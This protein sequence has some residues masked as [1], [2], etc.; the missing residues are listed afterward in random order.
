M[1]D[2]GALRVVLVC[3]FAAAAAAAAQSVAS[4]VAHAIPT[5]QSRRRSVVVDR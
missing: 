1:C 3:D 2:E 4:D 5:T